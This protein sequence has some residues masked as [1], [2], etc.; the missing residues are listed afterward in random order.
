MIERAGLGRSARRYANLL[1][2]MG[3]SPGTQIPS[4]PRQLNHLRWYPAPWGL[5]PPNLLLGPNVL[6]ACVQHSD[7]GTEY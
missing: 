5:Q 2:G 6:V 7:D 1:P 3:R 4:I